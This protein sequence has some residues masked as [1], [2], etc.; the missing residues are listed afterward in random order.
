MKKEMLIN[1]LQSEECRI[2]IVEDGVLEELYLERSSN[3]NYTGNIY[4]GK[5][6]NLEP[7]IQAAFVDFA[8]GRNGFLH[9]SDVEPQYYRG[10]VEDLAVGPRDRHREGTEA[11]FEDSEESAFFEDDRPTRGGSRND[12]FD[13]EDDLPPSRTS[14]GRRRERPDREEPRPPSRTRRPRPDRSEQGRRDRS[15]RRF[16]EGIDDFEETPPT[17]PQAAFSTEATGAEPSSTPRLDPGDISEPTEATTEP[18][19]DET[20][21]ETSAPKR[22]RRK[23]TG[24]SPRSTR[25]GATKSKAKTKTKASATKDAKLRD[26]VESSEPVNVA[27]EASEK[28]DATETR[29]RTSR[30]RS[31]RG[32]SRTAKPEPETSEEAEPLQGAQPFADAPPFG[33]P[34]PSL[35]WEVDRSAQ[36]ADD[37]E[38]EGEIATRSSTWSR[39]G[40]RGRS[41]RGSASRRAVDL[42]SESDPNSETA[43]SAKSSID[44][45][46]DGDSLEA[47][48]ASAT[49]I[50]RD[51][52]TRSRGGFAEGILPDEPTSTTDPD[53]TADE[54]TPADSGVDSWTDPIVEGSSSG[55]GR[56]RGRDA[57]RSRPASGDRGPSGRARSSER[58]AGPG[59]TIEPA[60]ATRRR[61]SSEPT[62][63]PERGS[64]AQSPDI[65]PGARDRSESRS[66]PTPP[67]VEADPVTSSSTPPRSLSPHRP[68]R[69][70][71]SGSRQRTGPLPHA[72][73][74]E[75]GYIPRRE[76]ARM[77]DVSSFD[78]APEADIGLS[79][80]ANPVPES[81]P[82]DRS[83]R[84]SARDPQPDADRTAGR[85]RDRDD[86]AE[87]DEDRAIDR[88]GAEAPSRTASRRTDREPTATDDPTPPRR[89]EPSRPRAVEDDRDEDV[90]SF[91]I[92]DEADELDD[93]D[94]VDDRRRGRRRRRRRRSDREPRAEHEPEGR[95]RR[96]DPEENDIPFGF[97]DDLD[98]DADEEKP[99]SDLILDDDEPDDD[100]DDEP[101]DDFDDEPDD[102]DLGDEDEL[103]PFR[104]R[105]GARRRSVTAET[106]PETFEPLDTELQDEIRREVEEIANLERELGIRGGEPRGGDRPRMTTATDRT[107]HKAG[108]GR[109]TGKPPIQDIF[110]RG[111]EVLIQVIK[112]SIGNKGPTLSTYISI[113]GRYLVLMPGLNRVGVSRKIA[114]EHQRRRLR[115]IM[116]ELDP[117]KGLGFIVRTAGLDRTKHELARDLAYLLRLWKTILLRIKKAKTPS[118]IYQESDMIIRTL[119]DIFNDSIDTVWI[120]EVS[121][122]EYA[123]EF[124]RNVMPHYVER[125]KLYDERVPLFHRYKIEEEIEKIQRRQVPLPEGGSIVIEQTEALV[126]IDVNSG[127][128]RV[129]DDAEKTAYEMNLRAAREI[130]RQLRLR[131]LGG[132]IVNDFIDMRDE[133]HRRG[134][135]R[136]L[137]EAVKRDR[138]R[139]K[140]LRMSAFG[141]IEMTRQRIRPSIKR[142]VYQ[143]CPHCGGSGVIKSAES[144]VI[145]VMRLLALAS[146]RQEVAR[147]NV[148]VRSDVAAYLNNRKRGDIVQLEQENQLNIHVRA[149]VECPADFIQIDCFDAN[150]AEIRVLPSSPNGSAGVPST[151]GGGSRRRGPSY[152]QNN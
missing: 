95:T 63:A 87:F 120:D 5:V 13:F 14:R 102:D 11:D 52:P 75:K 1:V 108:R 28:P 131:D 107:I 127:N 86:F 35:E 117:P 89:S 80:P 24:E 33:E 137:R 27:D 6:V 150:N 125:V 124:L 114:D 53:E 32:A 118:S 101:D 136:A 58:E 9:V 122:Y 84:R 99:V 81:R 146:H 56:L 77:A 145:D 29:T 23:A 100:F 34:I 90:E 45:D 30:T 126:A 78:F 128:F 98:L 74:G 54:P 143:D 39:V 91:E 139:T 85:R 49:T 43:R 60:R 19:A 12:D 151:S 40:S 96:D 148:R 66:E 73:A 94:A 115:K 119:R 82:D 103:E 147:I 111:D 83:V 92:P 134:V 25:A 133:K 36:D 3:E 76:R 46:F 61:G 123:R 41:T 140:V 104:G 142:S 7:A 121:A 88:G 21:A 69:S 135:E 72:K 38:E 110:R 65:I 2:A 144:V 48:S 70:S 4:K 42:E 37:S 55:S 62:P 71:G 51:R 113:P 59:S 8:V 18:P 116:T 20:V 79:V 93:F 130:A 129:Q 47:A 138:A 97:E 10:Q 64:S 15:R 50:G 31:T 106:E 105:R 109:G 44:A 112:E 57:I 141:I 152:A 149:E 16:G 17:D 67:V 26:A 68:G 22:R 132:V